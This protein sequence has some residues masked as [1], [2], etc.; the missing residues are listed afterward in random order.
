M[1]R[2]ERPDAWE[3]FSRRLMDRESAPFFDRIFD[4]MARLY[5]TL[6]Y[7]NGPSLDNFWA[8]CYEQLQAARSR[9]FNVEEEKRAERFQQWKETLSS[10]TKHADS[11]I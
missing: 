5:R 6:N 4:E 7:P 2:T 9:A 8:W 3:D 10:L 1:D 11:D